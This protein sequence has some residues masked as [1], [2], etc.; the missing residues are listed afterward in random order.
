MSGI[1]SST[2]GVYLTTCKGTTKGLFTPSD[3][4]TVTVTNVTFTGKMRM[5]PFLPIAVPVKKIKGATHKCYSDGDGVVRCEQ[6]LI[7]VIHHGLIHCCFTDCSV[8]LFTTR[9]E[10]HPVRLQTPTH[11]QDGFTDSE[12]QDQRKEGS[13]SWDFLS[14]LSY[15]ELFEDW[16][17]IRE[18]VPVHR[19]ISVFQ[20]RI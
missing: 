17:T 18:S 16:R 8:H 10:H 5:Q 19:D 20:L 12:V 11:P 15:K 13:S 1:R 3:S 14:T 9:D 6:A 4:V 2:N 7:V